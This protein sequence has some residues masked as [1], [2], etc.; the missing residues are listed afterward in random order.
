[1]PGQR[2]TSPLLLLLVLAFVGFLLISVPSFVVSQYERAEN[3]GS[4]WGYLYLGLIGAGGALLVGSGLWFAWRIW[5]NTVRK[6]RDLERG[7][8]NPSELSAREREQEIQDNLAAF[9]DLQRDEVIDEE[10]RAELSPLQ[11]RFEQKRQDRSLEI[12]AFGSISSGKSS[13]LNTLAGREMFATDLRGGTTLRRNEIPWPGMDRVTLVD[14]PGLGEV[15]GEERTRVAAAAAAGADLVLLVVDGPLRQ[16]EF[17]LLEQ[18]SGMEKRIILCLNKIDWYSDADRRSLLGQLREQVSGQIRP[19]DIV[20]VRSQTTQRARMRVLSDGRSTEETID[21]PADITPLADRMLK[22]VN[23]DGSDLLLAN[24]LLQSRGMVDAARQR[25]RESLD[26]RAW[27]IVGRYMWG[28]GGVAALSPF[29]VVD[30]AAGCAI[31]TKMVVDLARVYRQDIDVDVAVNLLGQLGK[32]LLAVLGVSVA[33]PAIAAVV[34]SM[35][36][37]VPGIGT[38]AGG[39]LQG[40]VLALVTRWIGSVFIEY[41]RNEMQEPRGGLSALA[42]REWDRL[43]TADELRKLVS[44]AR[45]HLSEEKSPR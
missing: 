5:R 19:E 23:K 31:S 18:L 2:R 13:L 38:I 26:K 3:L 16:S 24:L 17:V 14:T 29:P 8:R 12:V 25:V 32:S 20:S 33:T 27:Q 6:R 40:I 37:S 28:A 7:T 36:K 35:L 11:S 10:L 34:A 39:F 15:E 21:V 22:I 4:F 41:F 1:M 43:T 30:L 45:S 42:R 9:D 44:A